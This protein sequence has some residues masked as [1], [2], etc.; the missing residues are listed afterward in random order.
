MQNASSSF[1]IIKKMPTAKICF[2]NSWL[3][4]VSVKHWVTQNSV[5][6]LP[7]QTWLVQ[8][9][10]VPLLSAH[11][12]S[13]QVPTHHKN[14]MQ[15]SMPMYAKKQ[16]GKGKYL[17][18]SPQCGSS[19]EGNPQ[20]CSF[21]QTD[22]EEQAPGGPFCCQSCKKCSNHSVEEGC[23]V[24]PGNQEK[25]TKIPRST[26]QCILSVFLFTE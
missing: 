14:V 13:I 6:C 4:I 2:Q 18:L 10:Q 19:L 11:C 21:S 20:F 1:S 5:S 12:H 17:F 3:F 25:D 23:P 24:R 8:A 15:V 9:E 16:G 22:T 7:H 26:D